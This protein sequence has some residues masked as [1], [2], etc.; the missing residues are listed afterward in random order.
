M[1]TLLFLKKDSDNFT[2]RKN[3]DA[4]TGKKQR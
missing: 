4:S 2:Q 1:L 3:I